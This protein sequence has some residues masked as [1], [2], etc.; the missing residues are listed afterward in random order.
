MLNKNFIKECFIYNTNGYLVWKE[1]PLRHFKDRH[2]MNWTNSRF[3]NL[4]AGNIKNCKRSNTSYLSVTISGVT[5][6][7]HR[8]VWIYHNGC[9]PD[10]MQIDHIDNNGLNNRIENLRLVTQSLNQKN[11]P[12]QKSNKTGVN[13]V[14]WHKAAKKWQVRATDLKGNR[15]DLGRYADFEEAVK[16]RRKAELKWGYLQ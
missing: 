12:I 2:A 6:S 5:T 11:R 7:I 14:N 9:I 4:N 8:A 16:V 13:G 3:T 10:K 15:V 1:R